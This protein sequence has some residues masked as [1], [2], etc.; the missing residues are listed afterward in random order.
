MTEFIATHDATRAGIP[1]SS[2]SRTVDAPPGIYTL[3]AYL[4][5]PGQV[6]ITKMTTIM[7]PNQTKV[8]IVFP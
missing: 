2:L 6:A 1:I 7:Y 8:E 4:Y 5:P 3:K